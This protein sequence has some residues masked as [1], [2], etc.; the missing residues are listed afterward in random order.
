LSQSGRPKKIKSL[1]FQGLILPLNHQKRESGAATPWLTDAVC[2]HT[3]GQNMTGGTPRF[4]LCRPAAARAFVSITNP[5]ALVAKLLPEV[6]AL[7]C[8]AIRRTR[9]HYRRR[10]NGFRAP[11]QVTLQRSVQGK[12]RSCLHGTGVSIAAVELG[13]RINANQ[14]RR[15]IDQAV[16]T[17]PKG[18]PCRPVDLQPASRHRVKGAGEDLLR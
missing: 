18:L 13:R 6:A 1:K 12:S 14:L 15:W 10:R 16:G 9:G 17:L 4:S 3:L 8:I 7:L 11:S 5:I 2:N